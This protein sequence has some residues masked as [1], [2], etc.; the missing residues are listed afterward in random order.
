MLRERV[1]LQKN[2]LYAGLILMC[3]SMGYGFMG[4]AVL[5]LLALVGGFGLVMYSC[6]VIPIQ[7]LHLKIKVIVT[8]T[9]IA[10]VF[11]LNTYI[12]NDTGPT[13]IRAII[14]QIIA[15]LMFVAGVLSYNP[16]HRQF[17]FRP[18]WYF[19]GVYVVSIFGLLLFLRYMWSISAVGYMQRGFADLSDELNPV[20]V[21]YVQGCLLI[22]LTSA[23]FATRIFKARL[24]LMV[25]IVVVIA[26]IVVTGSRGAPL[27]VLLTMLY[28]VYLYSRKRLMSQR[29]IT[30]IFVLA[31]V[32]LVSLFGLYQ[33]G[34]IK[35]RFDMVFNRFSQ[36]VENYTG[37]TTMDAES[38]DVSGRRFVIWQNALNGW[39]GWWLSG[40]PDY[41][42]YPHNAFVELFSRFGVV[43]LVVAVLLIHVSI[44][45]MIAV[46]SKRWRVMNGDALFIGLFF[47][48]L[49]QGQTSLSLEMNRMLW[50]GAGYLV[51]FVLMIGKNDAYVVRRP[52]LMRWR[53]PLPDARP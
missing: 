40:D 35:N 10:G 48:C 39:T 19:W 22:V 47:F 6:V 42:P 46:W 16:A 17:G 51:V 18:R 36:L 34:F 49:L 14:F 4:G 41:S 45:F 13:D 50:L 9:V 33:I 11:V 52:V 32:L 7:C 53:G 8:A 25:G 15:F 2:L 21:A 28:L 24:V 1:N 30:L 44:R 20:G 27:F 3:A 37:D 38:A 26:C 43:G 29:T 23:L 5:R 31:P 12:V